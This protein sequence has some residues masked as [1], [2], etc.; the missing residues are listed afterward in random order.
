MILTV[1][2][3]SLVQQ[4]HPDLVRLPT[5]GLVG[6]WVFYLCVDVWI[7]IVSKHWGLGKTKQKLMHE[8]CLGAVETDSVIRSISNG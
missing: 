2:E 8:L 6:T 5:R 4:R 1:S 7:W 3:Q